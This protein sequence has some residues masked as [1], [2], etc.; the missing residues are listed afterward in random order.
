MGAEYPFV[1]CPEHWLAPGYAVCLHIVEGL[2]P[3]RSVIGPGPLELGEIRCA[4]PHA[5]SPEEF[6]LIC[7]H[8]ALKFGWVGAEGP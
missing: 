8:C 4:R 6:R 7:G 1:A 2:A 3:P 5:D